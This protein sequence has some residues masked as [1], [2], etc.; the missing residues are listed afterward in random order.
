MAEWNAEDL[1][2]RIRD[3]GLVDQRDLD[4]VWSELGTRD[5][6]H[7]QFSDRLLHKELLT[8]F[9]L[10]KVLKGDRVGFFYGKYRV[11]YMVEHSYATSGYVRAAITGVS[12]RAR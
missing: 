1:S 6:T 11:L 5:V 8:N 2:Q 12:R 4:I 7:E 9:Q 10:D 3:L